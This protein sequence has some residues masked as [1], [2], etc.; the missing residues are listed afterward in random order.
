MMFN[1]L[2]KELAESERVR[3]RLCKCTVV[4]QYQIQISDFYQVGQRFKY[5]PKPIFKCS[6]PHL[7]VCAIQ[8]LGAKPQSLKHSRRFA[9]LLQALPKP[10]PGLPLQADCRSGGSVEQAVTVSRL[11]TAP[12]GGGCAPRS[13]FSL[14]TLATPAPSRVPV[15]SPRASARLLQR[16]GTSRRQH[17]GRREDAT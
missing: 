6:C 8:L 2:Q 10:G 7:L 5:H 16:T 12:P 13:G 1:C 11:I 15:A 17:V 9:A 4:D 14:A 3:K